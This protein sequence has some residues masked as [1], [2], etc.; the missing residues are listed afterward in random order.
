MKQ[1]HFSYAV[2]DII[3][4]LLAISDVKC[5]YSRMI[6]EKEM[7]QI[8]VQHNFLSNDILF[9]KD[10]EVICLIQIRLHLKFE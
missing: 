5:S 3:F 10:K 1:N 2:F 4:Y 8:L 7:C 9:A 6:Y